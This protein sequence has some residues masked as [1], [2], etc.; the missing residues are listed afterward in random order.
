LAAGNTVI[1]KP[2][3]QAP[4]S[5]LRMAE[6]TGRRFG[7]VL[8]LFAHAIP[9]GVAPAKGKTDMMLNPPDDYVL[10]EG[11]RLLVIAEDDNSYAPAASALPVHFEALPPKTSKRHPEKV[12]FCGWRRDMADL[13]MH[14]DEFV[15]K[16]SELTLFCD[17]EIEEREARFERVGFEPSRDLTNVRITHEVGDPVSRKALESLPL[18]AFNSAL[19]LCSGVEGEAS[20]H[21][22]SRSLAT[23]L[24]I[25]DIQTQ[26]HIAQRPD[27]Q[28]ALERRKLKPGVSSSWI[29]EMRKHAA[30]KCEIISEILDTRTRGI[31]A[32]TRICDY[33]LSNELISKTLA[34][35]AEDKQISVRPGRARARPR[36]CQDA[37]RR[38]F[39]VGGGALSGSARERADSVLGELFRSEGNEIYI[40]PA[41][42]YIYPEE[43]LCFFEVMARVRQC[44]EVLIGWRCGDMP[45]AQ[46]NPNDKHVRRQFGL[47]DCLILLGDQDVKN[48]DS[49]RSDDRFPG[50][51]GHI[52]RPGGALS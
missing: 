24:L 31:I 42:E 6:L 44:G 34:M 27:L 51:G 9:C 20:V 52:R 25:R 7:E 45:R 28:Q 49:P 10:Q 43:E 15:P 33:V 40:R 46:I 2:P 41:G 16:G 50:G 14:M 47:S 22:D 19:I 37:R 21:M 12:L 36:R 5:S 29:G 4:L 32:E 13:V 8:R 39:G 38:C 1:V 23:L 17:L 18:E 30:R 11:D 26:R 3:E 48:P 35:V